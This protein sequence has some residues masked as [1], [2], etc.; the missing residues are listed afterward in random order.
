M[1]TKLKLTTF[2]AALALI[3][4]PMTASAKKPHPT[5][6]FA[7]VVE[8]CECTDTGNTMEVESPDG[9]VEAPILN[10]DVS[11]S[12]VPAAP[13]YGASVEFEAEWAAGELEYEAKSEAEIEEYICDGTDPDACTANVDI[14]V[15]DVP[16]GAEVE[17]E[18]QVKGF[19]N[20]KDG[21]VSRDFAKAKDECTVLPAVI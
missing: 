5:S 3:V 18:A 6:D 4:V 17:F 10:C 8:S 7:V 9:L 2:A 12:S 1:N 13:A 20:G 16:E 15:P 19:E 11:W 21:K 14:T